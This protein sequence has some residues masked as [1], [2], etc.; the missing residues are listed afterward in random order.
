MS[1]ARLLVQAVLA[2]GTAKDFLRSVVPTPGRWLEPLGFAKQGTSGGGRTVF[3]KSRVGPRSLRSD[4]VVETT[5]AV[6]SEGY[7]TVQMNLGNATTGESR[8]V[9]NFTFYWHPDRV[10]HSGCVELITTLLQR[11]VAVPLMR[12]TE[13]IA[14]V[15]LAFEDVTLGYYQA[16]ADAAHAHGED[17]PEDA[18]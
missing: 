9:Q 16:L 10:A 17:V 18:P 11:L 8:Y 6:Q 14:R 1:K 13:A 5:D 7:V 3:L 12:D 15:R 2:E 4:I